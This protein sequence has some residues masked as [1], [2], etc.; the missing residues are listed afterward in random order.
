[1][2]DVDN[3]LLNTDHFI[4]DFRSLLEHVLGASEADRF[5]AIHTGHLE[6][7]GYVD[8]LG[9][10]QVFSLE[11]EGRRLSISH[12]LEISSFL[13]EYPYYDRVYPQVFDVITRLN[14]FGQT[15]ILSDG[16]VVLQPRKIKRSGLWDAV[17]GRVLIYVHKELM[18]G[19]VALAY[20]ASHYVIV[21]DKPRILDAMKTRLKDQLTT[22][23]PLQGHYALDTASVAS[24]PAPDLRLDCIG[25][26]AQFNIP[27]LFEPQFRRA[28]R[29]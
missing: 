17:D 22:V 7:I 9:A 20:P 21:D 16:D 29:V 1:M 26:L 4:E 11:G 18:L 13:L 10:L 27:A 3:T 28:H 24:Y 5:W 23:L 6:K 2:L 15:V 12:W 14:V 25:D 19:A 8:Y